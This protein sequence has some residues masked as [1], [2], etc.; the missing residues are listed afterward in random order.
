MSK[1]IIRFKN[2]RFGEKKVSRNEAII[3]SDGLLGF[4]KNKAFALFEDPENLPFQ[5]LLSTENSKLGFVLINPLFIWPNYD[6]KIS[7]QDIRTLEA[8]KPEDIL[9]FSIVTLADD[10]KEVT[11]N[12]SGP[13]LINE[14]NRKAKQLALIDDRYVTKHKILDAL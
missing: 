9:M 12:L 14:N 11:A 2:F 4:E 8:S 6:P 1:E 13:I 5:W 10:P 3:F 7:C